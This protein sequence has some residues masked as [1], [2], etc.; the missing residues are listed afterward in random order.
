MSTCIGGNWAIR[1]PRQWAGP[2]CDLPR[3]LQAG[4][5][6]WAGSWE[7]GLPEEAVVGLCSHATL[8]SSRWPPYPQTNVLG[9]SLLFPEA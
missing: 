7:A 2:C 5:A 9:A 6:V 8:E 3:D 1:V 4:E